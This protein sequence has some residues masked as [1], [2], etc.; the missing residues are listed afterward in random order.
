[1]IETMIADYQDGASQKQL[2]RKYHLDCSTIKKML[3]DHDITIRRAIPRVNYDDAVK[4]YISGSTLHDLA[5]KYSV[6]KTSIYDGLLRRNVQMRKAICRRHQIDITKIIDYSECCAYWF[7][8]ILADGSISNTR[9]TIRLQR[10]D[11]DHLYKWAES[12]RTT[13][14]PVKC[15]SKLKGKKFPSCR[16]SVN[17]YQLADFYKS[18]GFCEFKNGNPVHI[19]QRLPIRHLLRGLWDGDG[20]ITHS[21]KYLRMGFISPYATNVYYVASLLLDIGVQPH[22]IS[23]HN[24]CFYMWWT[25]TSA[26]TIAKYLYFNQT[27]S[28]NRKMRKVLPYIS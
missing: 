10:I 2:A 24:K 9:M 16:M 7:G 12:L 5:I 8:F 23:E 15:W 17:H 18:H 14:T 11:I 28:L 27:I 22:K 13:I 6:S 26:V 19:P 1:M 21:S 4:L 20:I 25:G 3:I